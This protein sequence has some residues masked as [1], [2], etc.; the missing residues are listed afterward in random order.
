MLNG[1][2]ILYDKGLEDISSAQFLETLE[3]VDCKRITGAGMRFISLA[4]RLSNLT[5]RK[6]IGVTDEGMAE[7]ARWGKLDSLT[8]VGCP[9]ISREGVQGAA[10]LVCYSGDSEDH[11]SLKGSHGEVRNAPPD[12]ETFVA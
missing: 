2:S 1:A 4:P 12:L 11:D 3:L 8:V 10:R 6:C 9:L 5:L 7:L